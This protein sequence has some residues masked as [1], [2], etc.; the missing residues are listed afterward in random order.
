MTDPSAP[1][2]GRDDLIGSMFGV[3]AYFE[4]P[5][6]EPTI[7]DPGGPRLVGLS[8]QEQARFV[9]FFKAN[10][11]RVYRAVLAVCGSREA[12]DDATAEGFAR[13]YMHWSKFPTDRDPL[14][15]VIRVAWNAAV[16]AWRAGGGDR[17]VLVPLTD[18]VE[19]PAPPANDPE[20]RDALSRLDDRERQVVVMCELAGL[21]MTEIAAASSLSYSQVRELRRRALDKLRDALGEQPRE[22][23]A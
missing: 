2:G 20:V 15:W 4:A 1:D 18:E 23:G 12:A 7:S 22:G 10:H 9:R 5:D 3:A 19:R 21:R 11:T 16:D 17:A 6:S 13:A 8:A 14:G